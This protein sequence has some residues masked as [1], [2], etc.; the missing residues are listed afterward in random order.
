MS[1][2]VKDNESED[3]LPQ[4]DMAQA[5][6]ILFYQDAPIGGSASFQEA[7]QAKANF[8]QRIPGTSE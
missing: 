6:Q 4:P 3:K 2:H 5:E 7:V 8:A 1:D